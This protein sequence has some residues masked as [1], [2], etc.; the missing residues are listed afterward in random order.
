M[1]LFNV[2]DI[3]FMGISGFVLGYVINLKGKD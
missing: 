1:E 2:I 3:L